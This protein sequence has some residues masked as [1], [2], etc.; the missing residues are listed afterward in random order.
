MPNPHSTSSSETLFCFFSF[1]FF[2]GDPFWCEKE[3]G[4]P[5]IN[6]VASKKE[7][8]GSFSLTTNPLGFGL[9]LRF[10]GGG[11]GMSD[12]RPGGSSVKSLK[13]AEG[14]F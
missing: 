5:K 14:R 8:E 10:R 4:A 9:F 11:G 12:N 1:S 2:K 3:G 7:E 6:A 13:D